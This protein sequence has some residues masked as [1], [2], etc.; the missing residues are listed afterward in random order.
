MSLPDAVVP[1]LT[2][3]MAKYVQDG[4]DALVFCGPSA[5]HPP[6]RR[7]NFHKFVGW[8]AAT[9]AVG[10]PELHFHD[11]RDTGNTLAASTGA[12]TRDLMTRMGHDS[13]R[14]ALLY[15]H[16]TAQ[17]DRAIADAL[18][19][20]VEAL[21]RPEE[22][23]R[24]GPRCRAGE[25]SDRASGVIARGT[26]WPVNGPNAHGPRNQQ[27]P[28]Q[29]KIGTS[30]DQGLRRKSRWH[31]EAWNAPSWP[32]AMARRWPGPATRDPLKHREVLLRC[33]SVAGTFQTVPDERVCGVWG[34][35]GGP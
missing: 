25:G 31:W 12:S 34:R 19:A 28:G 8:K 35:L 22:A 17:A 27:G 20:A 6:L 1:D 4:P 2:E 26:L 29:R 7:S 23:V 33:W 13:P 10:V 32:S 18:N 30:G 5:K 16:A 3:H 9:A 21:K 14:A 24:R 15:Q 11:L